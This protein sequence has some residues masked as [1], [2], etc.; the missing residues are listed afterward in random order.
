MKTLLVMDERNYPPDMAE[1]R[2]TAVRGIIFV[3]GRLLLI[4]SAFGELKFPGGGQEPGESDEETLIR[5]AL[6]ETGYHV[7]PSSIRPFGEVE[8]KRLSTHEPMIWHQ[9]NRYYFCEIEGSQEACRY[10]DNE[11][12]YGFRQVWHSLEDAIRINGEMIRAEGEQP[13]NRREYT[14]LTMLQECLSKL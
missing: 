11:K 14:V 5:E 3:D 10:T 7:I 2:R 4:Q 13:W 8:E 6:E 1:I 12:K 9:F